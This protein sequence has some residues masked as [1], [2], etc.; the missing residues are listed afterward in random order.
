MSDTNNSPSP[1]AASPPPA[2]LA[3]P[4]KL[5]S[6]PAPADL[7]PEEERAYDLMNDALRDKAIKIRDCMHGEVRNLMQSR[8]TLGSHLLD[9]K[10]NPQIYGALSD[11]QLGTFFGDAGK[12]VYSEARRI[13]ERYSPERFEQLMAACNP[14]NGA[15]ISYKH[16]AL[17][18]RV[19]DTAAADKMLDHILAAGLSTKETTKLLNDKAK[20]AGD[21][22]GKPKPTREKPTDFQGT[23]GQLSA[24][25]DDWQEQYRTA[26]AKGQTLL[27]GFSALKDEKLTEELAKQ[28]QQ[29][30]DK[31]RTVS[32]DQDALAKELTRIQRQIQ[33]AIGRRKLPPNA[34]RIPP[35][36]GEGEEAEEIE[37]EVEV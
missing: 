2:R 10:Q 14:E 22:P 13:R 16:L 18:L 4:Q 25:N 11:I 26:W 21:G 24:F 12:T 28:V 36:V 37:E 6:L 32:E 9:V 23:L 29:V 34:N 5:G 17:L 35:G 33:D 1:A 30:A 3:G 19:E 15:R 8:Y 27:D 7:T 31:C 20:K